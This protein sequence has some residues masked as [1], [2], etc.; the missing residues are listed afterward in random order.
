MWRTLR[1]PIYILATVP[2]ALAMAVTVVFADGIIE[3]TPRVQY[4]FGYRPVVVVS[5]SMEPALRTNGISI[6]KKVSIQEIDKGD[7]VMYISK[8][9]VPV[10][11]RVIAFTE[12]NGRRALITKGDANEQEDFYPVTEDMLCGKSVVIINGVAPILSRLMPD[13][14]KVTPAYSLLVA[15]VTV[16]ILLLSI[17]SLRWMTLVLFVAWRAITGRQSRALNDA[18][19]ESINSVEELGHRLA[20]IKT[21]E[22]FSKEPLRFTDRVRMELYKVALVNRLKCMKRS[23]KKVNRLIKKIVWAARREFNG[24]FS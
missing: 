9:N 17:R 24:I 23:E 1:Y 19:S 20:F 10:M 22:V 3:G 15:F 4:Y 7:I 11:H 5:G 13:Y 18:L 12:I 21:A 8:N 6:I 2:L 16:V 14:R